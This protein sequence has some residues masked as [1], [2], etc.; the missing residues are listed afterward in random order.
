MK[1]K[2]PPRGHPG[3]RKTGSRGRSIDMVYV[4]NLPTEIMFCLHIR[5]TEPKDFSKSNNKD[6]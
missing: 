1:E 5:T 2:L 3:T 6:T 4:T